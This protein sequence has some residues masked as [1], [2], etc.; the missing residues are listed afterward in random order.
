MA[1]IILHYTGMRNE[2]KVIKKLTSNKSNVSCN[3]FIRSN[4]RIVQVVPEN[5]PQVC[6][7]SSGKMKSI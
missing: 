1:I 5:M 7:I 2:L 6:R 4:G 3:Y